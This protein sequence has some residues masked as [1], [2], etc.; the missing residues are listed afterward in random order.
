[1]P[2]RFY[3]GIDVGTGSARAG[4]FDGDGRMLA[5]ASHP[6]Q[7]W[8]EAGDVVEQSSAD[9]WRACGTATR[10]ALHD[11]N[12][13]PESVR[14]IGFDATC[15]LVALDDADRPV[16]VSPS[17]D[18]QRNVVVWMD[19]RALDQAARIGATTHP[20]LRYVGGVMSPEMESPKLLWLREH[21]P[22]TWRRT[23]RFFDLPDFLVYAA[24][25]VD[26]RSLCTTVCKW[27]YL[28]HE[29][30]A[31]AAGNGGDSVG[32]WDDTFFR[33]VGLG[34]LV[35]EGYRRIGR[36]IRPMGEPV[37]AGLSARAGSELGL[38][39]GT[40]VGV[41]I[42]DAHAGGL[43]VLGARL[44]DGPTLDPA[45]LE[46]RLALIGG[47]S[48]CH[49]AVSREARFVP[50]VWGPY[51]SAMVPGLWLTEGGQ[52]AT[53]SLVDHVVFGHAR[54]DE[55]RQ[56]ARVAGKT[57]YEILNERSNR[58]ASSAG[59]AF[60]AALTRD[61]HVLPYFHGNRSPRAD[62]TLRG[63][64]AGLKLSD[65]IDDTALLYLA[66]VQAIA[67]GTRHI[68]EAINA[69]GE[70]NGTARIVDLFAC[71]GGTKNPVF[72]REHADAG[73]L[74]VVLPREPE[75]VLLGSAVLG[76]VASGDRASVVEA[77]NAMNQ[78]G[79]VIE[80]ARGEVAR[81]HDAKYAVFHRMYD[82]FMAYRRAMQ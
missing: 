80:P 39:T 63:M 76:A 68:V 36:R 72:V 21:Q 1:V 64:V 53:G 3:L 55:L 9:I 51:F 19:H 67:Y 65:S 16:T 40:A 22:E 24:T 52:S 82:D 71:G 73:G 20:V 41:A 74:R 43:G 28:G 33:A 37:G 8:H 26:V 77:M 54:A 4:L 69:A 13:S 31:A 7:T 14:G 61:L 27:T 56:E 10:E 48:S 75:A 57:A 29:G 81:Y 2:H 18:D 34:D 49:M 17:G 46:T 5:A 59:V 44:G 32:R 35:D 30:G 66:T 62:P 45:A 60:P 6:I 78:A 70:K 25:G 15:S 42:I 50:G 12:V 38:A 11:A 23:A 58:L 47:T 79:Q